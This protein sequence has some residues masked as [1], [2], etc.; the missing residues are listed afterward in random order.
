[1][2]IN[3]VVGNSP[4]A[5]RMVDSACFRGAA[6][7]KLAT[8]VIAVALIGTRALAADMGV[9]TRSYY[10]PLLPVIY[11]WTGIYVGGHIGGAS[12]T[13]DWTDTVIPGLNDANPHPS[14]F[15]GGGQI[16]AN[17]QVDRFVVGVEADLS[18]ADLSNSVGGCFQDSLQSCS[19]K[20][21]WTSTLTGR[22]GW[23]WDRALFYGKAGGAW[24]RFKFEN[25]CGDCF[26]TDYFASET[27]SGWT[28]GGGIEYALFPNWSVKLE[29]DYLHFGNSTLTFVGTTGDTSTEIITNRIN[30]VKVGLNY[31]FY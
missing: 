11:D 23:A 12:G 29:Y 18:G 20:V 3:Y 31:R 1:M 6:I 25:P 21:E 19:T 24:A 14:G 13:S 30:E 22:V 9:P 28:V 7:K 17:Y 16:G 2:E 10:P 5:G 8:G 26:S 15:I 27:R 4:P